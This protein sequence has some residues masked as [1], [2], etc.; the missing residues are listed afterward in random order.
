MYPVYEW[1]YGIDAM[2]A[3]QKEKMANSWKYNLGRPKNKKSRAG[4][5]A[6]K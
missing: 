1:T 4:L 2:K 3:S 5:D 6:Y